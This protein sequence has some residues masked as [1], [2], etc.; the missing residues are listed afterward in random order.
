MMTEEILRQKSKKVLE[1]FNREYLEDTFQFFSP[2]KLK[3]LG[4]DFSY[5][6]WK[7]FINVPDEQFGGHSPFSICFKDETMEPFMFH[8]GGAEGRVP[9]LE[10]IKKNGKYTIGNEW[11]KE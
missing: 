11:K 6:V 5:D 8:D 4:Y 7:I 10:I 3:E 2:Q 1:D 9:D